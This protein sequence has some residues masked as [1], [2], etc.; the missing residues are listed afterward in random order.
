MALAQGQSVLKLGKSKP[1]PHTEAAL[2]TLQTFL[3]ELKVEISK[4]DE[5]NHFVKVT[6]I[7]EK[8]SHN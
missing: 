2:Y 7:A 5:G 6:G 8:N 3:P 1:T 4:D